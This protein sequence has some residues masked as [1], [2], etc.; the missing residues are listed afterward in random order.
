MKRIGFAI[1]V[2][3]AVVVA[4]RYYLSYS[5]ALRSEAFTNRLLAAI[6]KNKPVSLL[7]LVADTAPE[8]ATICVVGPYGHPSDFLPKDTSLGFAGFGLSMIDENEIAIVALSPS[9][10]VVDVLL[11]RRKFVDLARSNMRNR[12]YYG[13]MENPPLVFK[14]DW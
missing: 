11:V 9:G 6:D 13:R 10:E 7:S 1:L 4:G 8:V 5:R 3:I 14:E 12:C 2:V